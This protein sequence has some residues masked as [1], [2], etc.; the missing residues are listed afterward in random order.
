MVYL[1]HQILMLF[2]GLCLQILDN[3]FKSLQIA[4]QGDLDAFV[5]ADPLDYRPEVGNCLVGPF[6]VQ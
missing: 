6:F 2:F 3:E 1:L 5:V 4:S